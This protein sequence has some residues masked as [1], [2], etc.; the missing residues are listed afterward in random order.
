MRV[1]VGL[2]GGGMSFAGSKTFDARL[3]GNA[4][5]DGA[6]I[7]AWPMLDGLSIGLQTG[8]SLGGGAYKQH[9]ALY[10]QYVNVDY[11]SHPIQYT[12]TA[13]VTQTVRLFQI[14][15]P[16]LFYLN[17]KGYVVNAGVRLQ[18]PAAVRM[19][20]RLSDVHVLACYTEYKVEMDNWQI[21]GRVP[22]T[23][24]RKDYRGRLPFGMTLTM[25]AGKEWPVLDDNRHWIGLMAYANYA[26]VSAKLSAPQNYAIS[27]PAISDPDNPAPMV[28]TNLLTESPMTRL[29]YF[30]FGLKI[31]Y[32]LDLKK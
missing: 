14:E 13:E 11:L 29:H 32:T 3:G 30:D 17:Y 21:T 7:V 28:T 9:A 23:E 24:Q 15:I 25:E 26:P 8:L 4:L 5:A 6:F 16:V 22:E 31:Y 27:V 19:R 20:Q 1:N 2:R 10:E 18:E 12:N